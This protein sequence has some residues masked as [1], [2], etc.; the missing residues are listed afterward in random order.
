MRFFKEDSAYSYEANDYENRISVAI[1]PILEEAFRNGYDIR[2]IQLIAH[3]AAIV[4]ALDFVL[5]ARHPCY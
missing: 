1:R 3:N 4:A 5:N 2:D